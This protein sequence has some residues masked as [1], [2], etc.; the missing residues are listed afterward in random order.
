MGWVVNATPSRFTPGKDPVP[1]VQE[2]GWAPGPV[3][4]GAENLA[5]HQ[6]SILGPSSAV[7]NSGLLRCDALLL[8]GCTHRRLEATWCLNL[9]GSSFE[10]SGITS[11]KAE[12]HI[13]GEANRDTCSFH[14]RLY[15][16]LPFLTRSASVVSD[17]RPSCCGDDSLTHAIRFRE[18]W[19]WPPA[20]LLDIA[21]V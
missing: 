18:V 21:I 1:N 8:D 19:C 16:H 13:Q 17:T 20:A 2:A 11:P 6:D 4:T 5:P 3:W 9:R 7:E 14:P 15:K 12:S 10:T